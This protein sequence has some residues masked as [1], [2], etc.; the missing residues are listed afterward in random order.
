MFSGHPCLT[1]EIATNVSQPFNDRMT[2]TGQ[3]A[4]FAEEDFAHRLHLPAAAHRRAGRH[5]L[6]RL[7]RQG[8]QLRRL[9]AGQADAARDLRAG[10]RQEIRSFAS[11]PAI[12]TSA[13]A[14]RCSRGNRPA[15]S[16]EHFC[17]ED[18]MCQA[19]PADTPGRDE[20]ERRRLL[21][22]D[23]FRLP[24]AHR[25]PHDA[26]EQGAGQG[27][28]AR[29]AGL[30]LG[31]GRRGS[32]QPMVRL[33]VSGLRP[34]AWKMR[35][36]ES[37]ASGRAA[38]AWSSALRLAISWAVASSDATTASLIAAK[39]IKVTSLTSPVRPNGCNKRRT[40]VVKS[41]R[42]EQPGKPAADERIGAAP[43]RRPA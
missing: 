21:L 14:A 15:C 34:H 27:R 16:A 9:Q 32:R 8:P 43:V 33:D 6:P 17:R 12:S 19:F 24:D 2:V 39:V 1:G 42:V 38:N 25:Q 22:A 10:R 5:R 26:V 20:G 18:Y 37:V 28:R 13:S 4:A 29:G 11:R 23:L 31:R 40:H 3:F 36:R 41:C 35:G 30:P 7:Q